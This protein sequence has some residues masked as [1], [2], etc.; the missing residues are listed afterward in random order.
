[1][2]EILKGGDKYKNLDYCRKQLWEIRQKFGNKNT[3]KHEWDNKIIRE[4]GLMLLNAPEE[5][6]AIIQATLY[7]ANI[8]EQHFAL[9]VWPNQNNKKVT[10]SRWPKGRHWYAKVGNED[11]IDSEGNQ[12]WNTKKEAQKAVRDFKGE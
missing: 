5:L 3:T 9:H 4:L 6:E 12:K 2:E 10:Y 11:V 1:M 8:R 7:E